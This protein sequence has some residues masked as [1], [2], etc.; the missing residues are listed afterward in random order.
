VDRSILRKDMAK[1]YDASLKILKTKFGSG[2]VVARS[3]LVEEIMAMTS[4]MC[5]SNVQGR[6]TD[7]YQKKFKNVKPT[8]P[9]IW[10]KKLPDIRGR[11]NVKLV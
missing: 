5:I 6:L 11:V 3:V 7:M 1:I 10:I 9:G 8:T 4:D 2:K